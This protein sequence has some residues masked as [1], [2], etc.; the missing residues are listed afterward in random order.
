MRTRLLLAVALA[1][2]PS[3]PACGGKILYEETGSGGHGAERCDDAGIQTEKGSATPSTPPAEAPPPAP[4]PGADIP[5]DEAC[6]TF[7][8]RNAQCGKN[9]VDCLASC[10]AMGN[11]ACGGGRWLGCAAAVEGDLVCQVPPVCEQLYCDWARCAGGA[12]ADYCR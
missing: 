9:T 4:A 11:D 3:T 8:E 1:I 6:T 5:V 7:C 2:A 10:V 12:L